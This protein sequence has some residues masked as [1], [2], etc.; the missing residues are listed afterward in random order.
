MKSSDELQADLNRL[1]HQLFPKSASRVAQF[2][3]ACQKDPDQGRA[4]MGE[5]MW[6]EVQDM[7][8]KVMALLKERNK[9]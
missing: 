3:M 2:V 7:K 1:F 6:G 5:K 9:Q 8:A 4:R